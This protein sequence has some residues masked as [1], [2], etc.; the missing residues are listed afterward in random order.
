MI[1]R[2]EFNVTEEDLFDRWD[3]WQAEGYM[4]AAW[5]ILGHI[6]GDEGKRRDPAANRRDRG[7]V[8][9]ARRRRPIWTTQELGFCGRGGT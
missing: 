8:I 7:D 4:E 5:E 6:N 1:F 9:D 2:R 3:F